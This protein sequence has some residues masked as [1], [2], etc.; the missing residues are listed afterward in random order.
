METNNFNQNENINMMDSENTVLNT[1]TAA[2][3]E[4]AANPENQDGNGKK[5]AALVF[6]A[7]AGVAGAAGAAVLANHLWN[8]N[9]EAEVAPNEEPEAEEQA[10]EEQAA[11]AHTSKDEP[12][13]V[14]RQ[15]IVHIKPTPVQEPNV[16]VTP[17][18]PATPVTPVDPVN[19]V[20]PGNGSNV[21]PEAQDYLSAHNLH[22]EAMGYMDLLD[23][24]TEYLVAVVSTPEGD[25]YVLIDADHDEVF[26]IVTLPDED[27]TIVDWLDNNDPST[28][29][30]RDM[31]AEHIEAQEGIIID[32]DTDVA[33]VDDTND[34]ALVDDDDIDDSDD[35]DDA[36]LITDDNIDDNDDN[37]DNDITNVDNDPM[38]DI[39]Q[40]D[41][42]TADEVNRETNDATLNDDMMADITTVDGTTI[43]NVDTMGDEI[44]DSHGTTP[45]DDMMADIMPVDD[46]T[47]DNVDPIGD[48]AQNDDLNED[49]FDPTLND[50]MM[51]DI[52]PIEEA[53]I[54]N[55]DPIDDVI[56]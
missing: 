46:A 6:G 31:V 8:D 51:A 24:G 40:A 5:R 35:T 54:D 10:A 41:V 4:Y 38:A 32:N 56:A 44:D 25:K 21:E 19:P 17:V 20:E 12:D 37:G 15:E 3:E 52:S 33:L 55:I 50:D 49:T 11:E 13:V 48:L 29:V 22:V 27:L 53:P 42:T 7:V 30:D 23:D 18:T 47:I 16:E 28:F 9:P 45:N 26:D 34:T 14:I 36:T 43:D 1:M 2:R 39:A